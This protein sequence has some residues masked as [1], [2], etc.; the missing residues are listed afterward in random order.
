MPDK[1]E[2][3]KGN[4]VISFSGITGGEFNQNDYGKSGTMSLT[5]KVSGKGNDSE[6]STRCSYS[7]VGDRLEIRSAKITL[8]VKM[9]EFKEHFGLFPKLTCTS[10]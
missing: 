6:F 1:I 7:K 8:P 5:A 2:E 3:S 10:P 9:E 4:P